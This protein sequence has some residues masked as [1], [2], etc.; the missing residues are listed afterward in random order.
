MALSGCALRELWSVHKQS[1]LLP[2]SP[3]ARLG[4]A[5]HRLLAEAARGTI[6]DDHQSIENAWQ[7][8]ISEVEADMLSSELECFL[9][10][11]SSTVNDYEVQKLRA[12]NRAQQLLQSITRTEEKPVATRGLGCEV[13]VQSH[14][15]LIGGF[16]DL[17]YEARLGRVIREYK[18]GTLFESDSSEGPSVHP[19][20]LAQVKLYAAL[21][22]QTF[23]VWP[24]RLE[25]VPLQG[26]EV[27][28]TV[29]RSECDQFLQKARTKWAEINASIEKARVHNAAN[30]YSLATP[31][32]ATCRS[33][34]SR[35]GCRSYQQT[36][37]PR[38]SEWPADIVGTLV[39]SQLS[40]NGRMSLTL[41]DTRGRHIRVRQLTPA[42]HPA[43]SSLVEGNEVG[44][45]NVR[46]TPNEEEVVES[47]LTT[48]YRMNSFPL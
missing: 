2:V 35:P 29:D 27:Q 4:S 18:S 32:G 48:I 42:R 31:S 25:L 44:I 38:S 3:R 17:V 45:F 33:C 30:P 23:S 39:K 28:I 24:V 26:E 15:G 14:D 9:V 7:E 46:R 13:W 19:D 21:Y 43:L 10:P 12:C 6:L 41:R 16:I 1:R 37:E 40:G 34:L 8:V 22:H 11:L 5:I 36:A 47:T 20:Y